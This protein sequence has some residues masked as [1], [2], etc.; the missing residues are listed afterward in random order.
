M[1]K[2][3][4]VRRQVIE[5]AKQDAEKVFAVYEG[6]EDLKFIV[7]VFNKLAVLLKVDRYG[8]TEFYEKHTLTSK[9]SVG[10]LRKVFGLND[11]SV[12]Q[13]YEL[14]PC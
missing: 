12:R 14:V 7:K 1:C 10:L 2:N 8:G 6:G 13:F 3:Y 9:P 5:T 11:R 4:R